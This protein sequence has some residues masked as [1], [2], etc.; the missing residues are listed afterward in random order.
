MAKLLFEFDIE[1]S[2]SNVKDWTDQ[3]IYLVHDSQ[4]L[5]VVLKTR[6]SA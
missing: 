1:L 4:P 3:K 6:K 5:N 2:D